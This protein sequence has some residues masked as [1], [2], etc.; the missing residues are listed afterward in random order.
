MLRGILFLPALVAACSFG[1]PKDDGNDQGVDAPVDPTDPD[2]DGI[3]DGD[4]CPE[5]AN[6]DQ[7]DGDSDGVGDLCD[8]C[9]AAANAPK[10]TM[11][12]DGPVQRDHDGDGRGDECDPCPHLASA[13]L[14]ADRDSDGI[15]DNCDPEADTPNPAPYWNGFYE[16]PDDDW[17]VASNAGD[18]ADWELAAVGGKL[19]WRQTVLDGGRHQLL[20]KGLDR[21]EHFVQSSIVAGTIMPG[22]QL[23]SATVTYGFVRTG[24]GDDVYFSCGALHKADNTNETF[25]AEHRNSTQEDIA[26]TVWRVGLVDTAIDVTAR[27]DREGSTQPRQGTSKLACGMSDGAAAMEQVN[28][29]SNY[30]PDGRIGLRTFAMMAWFDYIFA[31]EPRPR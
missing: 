29:D 11:G 24:L 22:A 10:V 12:F 9:P 16:K 2:G 25:V 1:S 6:P 13:Q 26:E 4:N 18:K 8:N 27:G 3:K 30:F 19:G 20:L 28:L 7:A 17:D 15:G 5:V 21:Q 14:E 31:V 23:T